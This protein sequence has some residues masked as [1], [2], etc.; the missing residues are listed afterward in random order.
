MPPKQLK[1]EN[2]V[3]TQFKYKYFITT[4]YVVFFT[5]LEEISIMLLLITLNIIIMVPPQI[6][7][8][9]GYHQKQAQWRGTNDGPG[10]HRIQRGFST[11]PSNQPEHPVLF[12]PLL[13]E[14]HLYPHAHQPA[15][16]VRGQVHHACHDWMCTSRV[17]V[18]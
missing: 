9:L 17:S 3:N 13:H 18:E 4:S 7:W 14:P 10:Y 15:Q 12:G 11:G 2:K 8:C 5:E 16:W 1:E 6:C